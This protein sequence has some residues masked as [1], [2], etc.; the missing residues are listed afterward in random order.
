MDVKRGFKP[1]R[2]LDEAT[3]P[4]E[5]IPFGVGPRYCL[6]SELAMVEM[7]AFLA[8]LARKVSSFELVHPSPN[9]EIRWK[10]KAIIPTPQGGVVIQ[11]AERID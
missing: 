5:F 2:W 9:A 7:K 10:E 3:K 6:G 4:K 1:Q 11:P 8:V